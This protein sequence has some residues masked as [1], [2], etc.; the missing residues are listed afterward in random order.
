MLSEPQM[1]MRIR[2]KLCLKFVQIMSGQWRCQVYNMKVINKMQQEKKENM[3]EN[4]NEEVVPRQD[5]IT[6]KRF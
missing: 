4:K 6:T 3:I 2:P 1:S 5:I